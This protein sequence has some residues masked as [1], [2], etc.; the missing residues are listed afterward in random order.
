ME[1]VTLP[2]W[3][4]SE[5]WELAGSL[6]WLSIAF[7]L[8][9]ILLA[10][11]V[12][13]VAAGLASPGRP[14]RT[15]GLISLALIILAGVWTLLQGALGSG[16][17]RSGAMALAGIAILSMPAF[18]VGVTIWTYLGIANATPARV[19]I[20]VMVRVATLIVALLLA[21][22]PSL[23][24]SEKSAVR[25]ILY[26]LLDSSASMSILDEIDQAS[27]WDYLM[28]LLKESK[29]LLEKMKQ[30]DT[31]IEFLHF[32]GEPAPFDL[33]NPGKPE[34]KSTDIGNAFH[35]LTQKA[36]SQDRFR[37]LLLFGDGAD[38]GVSRQPAIPLALRLREQGC[39]VHAIGLG[40]PTTTSGQNDLALVSIATE[41]L[42]TIPLGSELIV[43]VGLN[44]FGF[45]NRNVG[46]Q[47][48]LDGAPVQC[49][50]FQDGLEVKPTGPGGLTVVASKAEGNEFV[51]KYRPMSTLG[52]I[53]VSVK[54]GDPGRDFL[55]LPGELTAVNN[56][57]DT[58]VTVVK[59]GTRVLLVDKMRAWEPQFFCDALGQDPRISLYPAWV[60]GEAA[61][62]D[63]VREL[64]DLNKRHYDAVIF[65]DVTPEQ[66]R[67]LGPG[68]LEGIERAVFEK[69]TGFLMLGGYSSFGN[70]SWKGTPM[71]NLL[72]V[73]LDASGQI[74]APLKMVPTEDGLR[75]YSYILKVSQAPGVTET[76]AK[77]KELD[78]MTKLGTLKPGLS[79]VLAVSDRNDPMLVTQNY[80]KGRTL[81]FA[82]DTTYKWI[83]NPESRQIHTRF[84]TQMV[85]WLARQE[86]MEGSLAVLPDA[87]RVPLRS[88]LGF[89]LV[90]KGKQGSDLD[91]GKFET[92]VIGPDG[93]TTRLT[94]SRKNGEE[95]GVVNNTLLPG[96]YRI[97][98]HGEGKDPSG[99]TIQG[100]ASARFMVYD[101][102][103]EMT[104]RAADHEFLRK[105]TVAGGG[106]FLLAGEFRD[107]LQKLADQ[108]PEKEKTGVKYYPDWK[109]SAPTPFFP[110]ALLGFVILVTSEWLLR[111]VWGLV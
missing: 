90:L 25:S 6:P 84:W 89:R 102:D 99:E 37:G 82:A 35:L 55:P 68:V 9:I 1:W 111:R 18:L 22:R 34:G 51:L 56:Q 73:G 58:Y 88:E 105:L 87:R 40:K 36:R 3:P 101:E 95:R 75:R 69:G 28:E 17:L 104:R 61:A 2:L 80:G 67:A 106:Q 42:P 21:L 41:P 71:E 15:I 38:N 26:L 92:R 57:I 12:L 83:R 43:K 98:V 103:L 70:S 29:P 62:K 94:T 109:S 91:S 20:L 72:P 52:E 78:G 13:P 39:P 85:R 19:A 7:P 8:G 79:T 44:A 63:E 97:E 31:E 54:A 23:A 66:V 46:L 11:V 60:R 4:W 45:E 74:E 16:G 64:F 110:F 47:L 86:E 93:T 77:L 76:W 100:K 10:M 14:R 32:A 27:R 107:F 49:K 81:A 59:E 5:A 96:E 24:L 30:Q 33:E 53:K 50:I 108:P 65:G 48:L